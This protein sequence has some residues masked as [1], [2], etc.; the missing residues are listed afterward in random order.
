MVRAR[1]YYAPLVSSVKV[2]CHN[3]VRLW[4]GYLLKRAWFEALIKYR[5]RPVPTLIRIDQ[6][7]REHSSTPFRI[8]APNRALR[9]PDELLDVGVGDNHGLVVNLGGVLIEG[10]RGL[11]A[12]VAVLEVE[13]KRAD[14][15]RATDA[16]ELGAALDPL[17]SVVRHNLIVSPRRR[18]NAALWSGGEG[19]RGRP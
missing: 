16:G 4:C 17:S 18:G 3:A 6:R 19:N 8:T 9:S 10:V 1:I 15:V 2:I 5:E 12:E 14:A 7:R 11:R 13:V